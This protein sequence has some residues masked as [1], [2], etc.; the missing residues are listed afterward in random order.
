MW[1]FTFDYNIL[2]IHLFRLRCHHSPMLTFPSLMHFSLSALFLELSFQFSIIHLSIS[3]RTPFHH[4]FFG[5]PLIRLP[6]GL[7]SNILLTLV[8]YPI[9][10]TATGVQIGGVRGLYTPENPI[11]FLS[12]YIKSNNC[13][14]VVQWTAQ[15]I[16]PHGWTSLPSVYNKSNTR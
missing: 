15:Q 4:L 6:W 2:F 10:S 13:L 12:L 14:S 8:C 1:V 9:F 11:E 5:L 16:S 7:L 3:V